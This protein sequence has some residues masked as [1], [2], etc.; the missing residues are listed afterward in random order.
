LKIEVGRSVRPHRLMEGRW[1]LMPVMRV[2]IPLGS[3][4]VVSGQ[5][6][7]ILERWRSG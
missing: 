4:G 5:G 6:S 7:E 3:V 1:L 2:R